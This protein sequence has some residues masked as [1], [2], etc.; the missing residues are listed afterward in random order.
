MV[1]SYSVIFQKDGIRNMRQIFFNKCSFLE[2]ILIKQSSLLLDDN[3]I[4]CQF[5]FKL[6]TF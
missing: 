4:S 6:G 2:S 1:K 5:F 3:L